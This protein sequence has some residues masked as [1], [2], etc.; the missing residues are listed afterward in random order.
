MP[1]PPPVIKMVLP[2]IFMEFLSNL[3]GIDA[4]IQASIGYRNMSARIVW[5]N[6][7]EP[8]AQFHC[9]KQW[10]WGKRPRIAGV[11]SQPIARKT[12]SATASGWESIATWLAAMLMVVAL[13]RLAIV[14][15][16]SG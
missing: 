1:E 5:I 8:N 15:C 2:V 3:M 10:R 16:S 13:I 7:P 6:R 4:P 12:N 11:G 9:A 14:C